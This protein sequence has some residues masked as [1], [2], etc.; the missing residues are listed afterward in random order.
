MKK[1]LSNLNT[2]KKLALAAILL[3][4][5]GIFAASPYNTSSISVNAK[6]LAL[7]ANAA[8]D[9]VDV[10]TLADWIIKGKADYRLIDLRSSKEYNEY[11]IPFAEN[12]PLNQINDAGLLRNEKLVLYS[13]SDVNSAQA[14]FILKS[15]SYKS[16]YILSGG[17]NEWKEKILYPKT[18]ADSSADAI[19]SFNKIKEVSKYFGGQPQVGT[20]ETAVKMEIKAPKLTSTFK[21]P[22][23]GG[24][25][26]KKE[27]C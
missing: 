5:I 27:G 7:S 2:N 17:L 26:K 22:A 24:G 20:T 9:K 6:E 12:I 1:F 21:A 15:N 8:S 10:Y 3:G 25:K 16:V 14:W 23:A 13:S 4:F 18:P 11:S 19:A